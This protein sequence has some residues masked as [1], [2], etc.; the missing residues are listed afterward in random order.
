[1]ARSFLDEVD[2]EF[3]LGKSRTVYPGVTVVHP[4]LCI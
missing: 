2:E 4:Y 1:M 3:D